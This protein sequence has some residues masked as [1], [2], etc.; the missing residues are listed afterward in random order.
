MQ[1]AII[2][3][4]LTGA[5][6]SGAQ[7]VRAGY[8]TA[9]AFHG[10]PLPPAP[11][12][13]AVAVDTDSRPL[14]PETAAERV[15]GAAGLL[16]E[17]R[18]LYK[19]LDSTLR[20]PVAA[21]LAAALEG[22]G[23]RRAVVAPAF[24]AAGRTTRKGVQL[25]HGEPLPGTPL[26]VD[27]VAPVRRAHIPS[28]LA[29]GGLKDV[30]T[31]GVGELNDPVRVREVLAEHEWTVADAAEETH[32]GALVEAVPDPS[33]VL[34]AGSAGLARALGE[35]YPGPKEVG[36]SPARPAPESRVLVIAGSTNP[37]V[38]EQLRRLEE[39]PGVAPV[40]LRSGSPTVGEDP[41]EDA[42][43]ACRESLEK[44]YSVALHTSDGEVRAA[45]A[46]RIVGALA[47]VAAALA[48][49]GL[50]EALVLTGGDT[51]VHVARGL[52]ARGILLEG[53]IEPGVPVGTLI[54]ARPY[55][56][57]TKAGG[58]GAPGTLLHALHELT[59]KESDA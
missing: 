35:L 29:V 59:G 36:P 26:A 30:G 23:R 25:L 51:A 34:W 44:G 45:D 41:A 32:L 43:R 17:A 13:D 47:E 22:S 18:I 52:G 14:D 28:L 24:P 33:E 1:V 6:D 12:L 50:F 27:P 16:S 46:G 48:E 57:I 55:R 56:V 42:L 38:R 3:D 37:V 40:M 39:E 19:K 7:L 5:T 15:R 8:R 9:V 31:L 11:D 58:F 20:G 53:E 10:S 21:E 4:D 2:A 49:E 54:C